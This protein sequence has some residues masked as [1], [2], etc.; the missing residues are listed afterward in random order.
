MWTEEA[1][2]SCFFQ[3]LGF[4]NSPSLISQNSTNVATFKTVVHYSQMYQ[5]IWG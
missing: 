3:M 1:A 5:F 4:L 2:G